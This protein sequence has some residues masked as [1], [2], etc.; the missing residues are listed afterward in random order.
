MT[1]GLMGC[2][3]HPQMNAIASL[4]LGTGRLV[5]NYKEKFLS[6]QERDVAPRRVCIQ[7]A[8]LDDKYG[9]GPPPTG[10]ISFHRGRSGCA[11]GFD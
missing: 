9:N 8:A 7:R 1:E 11:V 4:P 6:G 2:Y 5:A 10:T 3:Y